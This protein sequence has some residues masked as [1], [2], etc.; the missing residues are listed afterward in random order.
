MLSVILMILKIIGIVLLGLLGLV[1]F[2][3]LLLL[4][5]PVRYRGKA[6]K[7][8]NI[9]ADIHA[10]WLL[11]L[12]H[13][14]LTYGPDGLGKKVKVFGISLKSF[15]TVPEKKPEEEEPENVTDETAADEA[16][17][18]AEKEVT[19][20]DAKADNKEKA[21]AAPEAETAVKK[22]AED[23][24]EE[25]LVTKE[26]RGKTEEKE[27]AKIETE[28]AKTA[29]DR[30]GKAEEKAK[31]KKDDDAEKTEQEDDPDAEKPGFFER[32]EKKKTDI[33][34]MLNNIYNKITHYKEI[35]D[36]P[37]FKNG[38]KYALNRLLAVLKHIL[39]RKLKGSLHYGFED[40][41]TTGYV[42]AG[43]GILYG[44]LHDYMRFEP[45]F[46]NEVL[47]GQADFR[48]HVRLGTVLFIALQV[49]LKKDCRFVYKTIKAE[50][51]D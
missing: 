42:T 34:E 1:I 14:M 47:E 31:K 22:E 15:E 36:D 40:P 51:K 43:A 19:D 9:T 37:R 11:H 29:V 48:G 46:E 27:S 12:V 35:I 13:F 26:D 44:P 41:S 50:G 39:P 4:L 18:E 3:L 8:E 10:T 21:E 20:A 7:E 24:N 49:I 5:V 28:P 6:A 23:K 17:A 30:P 38:I 33:A 2:L 16:P 25:E 45:D 32:L